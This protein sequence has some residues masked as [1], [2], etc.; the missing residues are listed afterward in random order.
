MIADMVRR[1][2]ILSDFLALIPDMAFMETNSLDWL[3]ESEVSY[4]R[5][6]CE[7]RHP[8]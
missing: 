8:R 1:S 4:E 2:A 5:R 3:L 7:C 6:V